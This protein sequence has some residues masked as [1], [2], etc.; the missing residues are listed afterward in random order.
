MQS[1]ARGDS[2]VFLG[3]FYDIQGDARF[4]FFAMKSP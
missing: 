2:R 3:I 4:V 1:K